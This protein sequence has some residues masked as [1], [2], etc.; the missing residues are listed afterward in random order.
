[1]EHWSVGILTTLFHGVPASILTSSFVGIRRRVAMFSDS[2]FLETPTR[3]MTA[4]T[5]VACSSNNSV[6]TDAMAHPLSFSASVITNA[7]DNQPTKLC[8][9][10]IQ[11]FH[12]QERSIAD[13]LMHE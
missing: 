2:L 12:S 7:G 5:Q 1:V 4:T 13:R 3:L 10:Q 11:F 6:A 9:N 8:L